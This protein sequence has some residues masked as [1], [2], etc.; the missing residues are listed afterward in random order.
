[1]QLRSW[2]F[3]PFCDFSTC[4]VI[5]MP[6]FIL[7]AKFLHVEFS[8]YRSQWVMKERPR[9]VRRRV[10]SSTW[11]TSTTTHPS[12]GKSTWRRWF[13]RSPT[14]AYSRYLF[15]SHFQLPAWDICIII[16]RPTLTIFQAPVFVA[17]DDW[18]NLGGPKS[19][20]AVL[21]QSR[22]L[23]KSFPQ[24]LSPLNKV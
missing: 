8:C 22:A 24:I 15:S 4:I 13:Q 6:S 3:I 12:S 9:W 10:S 19:M 16:V 17:R 5:K 20:S 7:I 2:I 21:S 23:R 14:Q 18:I 11:R 1:M